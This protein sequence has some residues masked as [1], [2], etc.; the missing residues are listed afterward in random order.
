MTPETE[1]TLAE[2]FGATMRQLVAEAEK[3]I[4]PTGKNGA[5]EIGDEL[6]AVYARIAGLEQA[7][8]G[9]FEKLA[10]ALSANTVGPVEQ[11]ER[12]DEN[13][14]ALRNTESVNQ[15]LFNSLHEELKG[16]RDNLLRETMQ[17][18]FIRD[19]VVLLDDLRGWAGQTG[20]AENSQ[21]GKAAQGSGG[22]ENAVH[23]VM[24]IL[25]R[26]EVSEIEP[27]EKVD[28][29]FHKVMRFE[30]ATGAEDDGRIVERLKRGFIWRGQVL[31]PEEVVA[32]RF[33]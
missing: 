3:A 14:R 13:L 29:A 23:S 24:E 8:A 20:S 30:P 11:M 21:E 10:T 18:P 27:K 17:K 32:Q 15:R 12:M 33:A 16:Y 4:E 28:R 25:E 9:G 6:V 26:M 1:I 5:G 31:R 2:D 22:L 19:L 7:I